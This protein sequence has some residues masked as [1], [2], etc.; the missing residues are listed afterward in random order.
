MGGFN[1]V[2]ADL[3]ANEVTRGVF[4]AG[5]ITILSIPAAALGEALKRVP[6][7]VLDPGR[8]P[9][10]LALFGMIAGAAIGYATIVP[11]DLAISIGMAAGATSRSVHDE[12]RAFTTKKKNGGT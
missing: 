6:P 12:V 9:A 4:A 5:L 10:V 11:M 1:A 7:V 3:M 2:L 8:I